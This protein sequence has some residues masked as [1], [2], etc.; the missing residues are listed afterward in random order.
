VSYVDCVLPSSDIISSVETGG[1]NDLALEEEAVATIRSGVEGDDDD[2][3]DAEEEETTN[4]DTT[5]VDDDSSIIIIARAT[6]A[7]AEYEYDDGAIGRRALLLADD[8][9]CFIAFMAEEDV[10]LCCL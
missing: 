4:P 7:T 10:L 8:G 3:K 2:D 9:F 5:T 1:I 6:A